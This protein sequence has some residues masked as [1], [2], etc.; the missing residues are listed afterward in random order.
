[1]KKQL[2]ISAFLSARIIG[3]NMTFKKNYF[4]RLILIL[5]AWMP[6]MTVAQTITFSFDDGNTV[7]MVEKGKATVT[8]ANAYKGKALKMSSGTLVRFKLPLQPAS[9][10][11]LTAWLRTESGADNM[12]M[13]VVGIGKNNIS[14]TTALA[15]W[16][17]YE[18]TFNVSQDQSEADLE[19]IFRNSQGTTSVWVDEINISRIGDYH[20]VEYTGIPAVP[21]RPIKTD[22]GIAMQPDEKI[23]WMLDDKLGLFIHWGLYAGPAQG[24][25]HMEYAGIQPDEYR[26]LA[27]PESGDKYF[28]AKDFDADKWMA[29]AKK[30][31]ARYAVLTAQHHDGY[32]LFESKYMNAFTSKQTHNRDFVKEYVEACRKAGLKVGLYK[33]LINWR[34]RTANLTNSAIPRRH[35]IRKTPV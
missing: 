9:T 6:V 2:I 19:F 8:D 24:E 28:D 1:M 18:R 32:A 16:T 23:K 5:L 13:Q 31:G 11:R 3:N 30:I 10:Y 22:L 35:G 7:W 4:M 34:V 14:L 15:T 12:S 33:T 27:Y 17:K 29:L 26:K 25:W 20:E 21:Q